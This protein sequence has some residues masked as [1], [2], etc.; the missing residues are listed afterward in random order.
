MATQCTAIVALRDAG[1]H[2]AT[3]SEPRADL[4]E[5]VVVRQR[6]TRG[7]QTA[8]HHVG[9]PALAEDVELVANDPMMFLSDEYPTWLADMDG[10]K[11]LE[12]L[13]AH[14]IRRPCALSQ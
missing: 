3:H 12:R 6:L 7:R 9:E 1:I 14:D 11:P 10:S 5:R 8:E 4:P 2:A 13:P